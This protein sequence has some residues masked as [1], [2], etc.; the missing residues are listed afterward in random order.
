MMTLIGLAITLQAER[1]PSLWNDLALVPIVVVH[2]LRPR[3]MR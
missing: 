2:L 3:R 1:G